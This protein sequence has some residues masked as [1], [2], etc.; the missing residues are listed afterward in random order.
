LK[1]LQANDGPQNLD[2]SGLHQTVLFS[3]A[4]AIARTETEK[5]ARR[6]AQQP[7]KYLLQP[8]PP[9]RVPETRQT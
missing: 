7:S 5:L 9:R 3:Y 1:F 8:A 6:R 2:R 4:T